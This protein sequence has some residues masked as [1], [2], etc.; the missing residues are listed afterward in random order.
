MNFKEKISYLYLN[1][2]NE[3][4]EIDKVNPQKLLPWISAGVSNEKLE[5]PKD[6][7]SPK[8]LLEEIWSCLKTES[9]KFL[10]KKKITYTREKIVNIYI[11]YLRLDN[12][13]A[14]GSDLV[15]YGLFSA[16]T[17]N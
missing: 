5:P 2:K 9:F 10:A 15:R 17:Y 3:Y 12:T 7:N 14:K 8:V 4:F 11:V 1:Q 6:E 16:T 13:D